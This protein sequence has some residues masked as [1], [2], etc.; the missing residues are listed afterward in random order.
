MPDDD[1]DSESDTVASDTQP[2]GDTTPAD[3]TDTGDT[4]PSEP[5]AEPTNPTEPTTDPTSEPT[6]PTADP[7]TE[8]TTDPTTEPTN[9]TTEP[10]ESTEPT[11][12]VCVPSCKTADGTDKVCGSDGCDGFCGE[13]NGVCQGENMG[14]S[15]DQTQCVKY[16]CTPIA[17]KTSMSL[18]ST[19]NQL[20]NEQ[21]F[22]VSSFKENENSETL[23]FW[24]RIGGLSM[25]KETDLAT[26]TFTGNCRGTSAFGDPTDGWPEANSVCLYA[27]N[28][29]GSLFYFADRGTINI[30]TLE[31]DG[32]FAATLSGDVRLVQIK[33]SDEKC[34]EIT[35]TE[36]TGNK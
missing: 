14:C 3:P 11:D 30:T 34:L 25:K 32:N 24:I 22:Y 1:E 35:T 13:N 4:D 2:S 5:T 21:F 6:N 27:K 8:P 36:I 7:T 31:N 18:S 28:S 10:T 17:V 9:P 16:E 19:S 15:A 29:N 33:T 26:M 12:P 23:D 20:Q